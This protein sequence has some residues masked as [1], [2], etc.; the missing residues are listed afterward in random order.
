MV[1]IAVL[2]SQIPRFSVALFFD[3]LPLDLQL[4][5]LLTWIGSD[6]SD[7]S[8]GQLL[9]TLS[10]LD[11]ACC[12]TK[13]RK[14]WLELAG[15]LYFRGMVPIKRYTG[16]YLLWLTDRRVAV[17]CL[18]V[19]ERILGPQTLTLPCLTASQGP[20]SIS[21]LIVAKFVHRPTLLYV[22]ACCP[23]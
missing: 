11:I 6:H 16:C 18:A 15:S 4:C 10:A 9:R 23:N 21:E 5:V 3:L 8:D 22:L 17:R 7:D 14:L 20:A 2:N 12:S 19:D 13:N 1:F